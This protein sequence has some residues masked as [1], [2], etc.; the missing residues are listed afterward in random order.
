VLFDAAGTLNALEASQLRSKRAILAFVMSLVIPGSGLIYC[1]KAFRGMATLIVCAIAAYV[2]IAQWPSVVHGMGFWSAAVTIGLSVYIFGF[3]DA[4]FTA[5]E[6]T[7]GID[8]QVDVQNP[9]VAAILNFLTNGFGYF[10]LGERTKGFSIFIVLFLF[11][12]AI[13]QAAGSLAALAIPVV[14]ATDGYRTAKR[15]IRESLGD[16]AYLA[17]LARVRQS[18]WL[19]AAVP[20]TLAI[21]IATLP[22]SIRVVGQLLP[23]FAPVDQS[24]ARFTKDTTS[25]VYENPKYAVRMVIPAAWEF[26]RSTEGEKTH[27][28]LAR[29]TNGGCAVQLTGSGV[30]PL[31][32]SKAEGE[33]LAEDVLKNHSGAKL[34]T[35]HPATLGNLNG[36][37]L[38]FSIPDQD[39]ELLQSYVLARR[40]L[41]TY[42]MIA[43]AGSA[44]P[45]CESSTNWI[46]EHLQF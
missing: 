4:F 39:T 41:V 25:K 20:L 17:S 40:D 34:I 6:V 42:M 26:Q 46:R 3:L 21:L 8:P 13:Y 45:E 16:D 7:A 24:A 18:S 15:Q 12:S 33:I 32:T 44:D 36:Y 43:V 2:T 1:E 29:A 11:N 30:L 19:P 22:V 31:R 23:R 37:Q 10:Y 35:Q 28:A 14:M 5:R 27:L 38:D 9:R